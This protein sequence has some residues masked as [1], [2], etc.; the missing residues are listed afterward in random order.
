M[1]W[2][3]AL[4]L[5][6]IVGF[7][8]ISIE[9]WR[10]IT[11]LPQFSSSDREDLYPTNEMLRDEN[12]VALW[13][14]SVSYL[15]TQTHRGFVVLIFS[16]VTNILGKTCKH[17]WS[18]ECQAVTFGGEKGGVRKRN[19]GP[20]IDLLIL[21]ALFS[22]LHQMPKKCLWQKQLYVINQLYFKKKG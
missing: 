21:N 15:G 16:L 14:H 1:N 5:K 9:E 13:L 8:F 20:E 2:D 19:T 4:W 10:A 6:E 12:K 18:V 22:I 3:Y 11:D 17:A 7:S